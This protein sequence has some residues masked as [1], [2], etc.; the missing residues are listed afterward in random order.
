MGQ[1]R[2]WW[3]SL[4]LPPGSTPA[5]APGCPRL[6]NHH[7]EIDSKN[8]RRKWIRDGGWT[9]G[10][11]DVTPAQR[12]RTSRRRR[13]GAHETVG[14]GGR[15]DRGA[16]GRWGHGG[17]GPQRRCGWGE[18]NRQRR[19]ERGRHRVNWVGPIL[20]KHPSILIYYNEVHHSDPS[21]L[22][23]NLTATRGGRKLESRSTTWRVYLHANPHRIRYL[24]ICVHFFYK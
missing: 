21:P 4:F 12:I 19:G 9:Q 1:V 8:K 16:V 11:E 3:V 15:G 14:S 5:I 2:R 24:D 18:G 23:C 13:R 17:E 7:S 6:N 20:Q 10:M 22:I